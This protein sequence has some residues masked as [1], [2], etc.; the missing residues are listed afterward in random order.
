MPFARFKYQ[1]FTLL[2]AGGLCLHLHGQA[3]FQLRIRVEGLRNNKGQL[4]LSLFNRAYGFPDQPNLS[5]RQM[6][7]PLNPEQKPE[8]VW[9]DLPAGI[10]AV[11][12]LHDE[13]DDGR[14][15]MNFLGIPTEGVGVSTRK[16]RLW[17]KPDFASSAFYLKEDTTIT[18]RVHYFF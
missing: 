1:H 9:N 6:R 11:A 2:L 16:K 12:L 8:V 13:D 7:M 3:Q 4:L 18:I 10:Y 14:C 17:G 15:R 5:F